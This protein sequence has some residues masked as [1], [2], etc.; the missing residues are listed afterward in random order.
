VNS[1][2]T[3]LSAAALEALSNAAPQIVDL[4][5]ADTALDDTALGAIG[6]LPAVTHLR[7]ARNRLTDGALAS[8]AALPQLAYLNVYAN[9]QITDAG[10]AQ[11]A[12]ST[13]LRELYVWQ[14]GASAEGV[15]QLRSQRPELAVNFGAE[16]TAAAR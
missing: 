11:L 10:L 12:R 2:G 9:A 6:T 14:T 4:N 1:P 7:L 16:P 13:S 8:L 3:P 5:L 15:A